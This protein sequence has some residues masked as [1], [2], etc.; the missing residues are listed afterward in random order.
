M[1]KERAAFLAAE[2]FDGPDG[3]SPVTVPRW[4][5]PQEGQTGLAP[6]QR[7]RI[8]Q[9]SAEFFIEQ[10]GFPVGRRAGA[11]AGMGSISEPS[12]PALTPLPPSNLVGE[13]HCTQKAEP[14]KSIDLSVVS[15]HVASVNCE[16]RVQA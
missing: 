12:V 1:L 9:A 3:L 11:S 14:R 13:A 6:G 15:A 16:L 2:V 10:F 4:A 8:S 7:V 5:L